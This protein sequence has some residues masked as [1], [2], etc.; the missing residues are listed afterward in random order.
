M[1]YRYIVGLSEV[2]IVAFSALQ[3]QNHRVNVVHKNYQYIEH[4]EYYTFCI[5]HT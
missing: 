5:E 1:I 3:T 2:C 4:I